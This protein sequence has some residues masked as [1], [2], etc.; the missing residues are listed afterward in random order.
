M[1]WPPLSARSAHPIT[2]SSADYLP[3]VRLSALLRDSPRHAVALC[4]VLLPDYVCFGYELP[5]VCKRAISIA[6]EGHGVACVLQR[7]PRRLERRQ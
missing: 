1:R 2:N 5:K 7:L 4:R 3:R 6:A